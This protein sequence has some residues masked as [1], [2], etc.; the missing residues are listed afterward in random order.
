MT[1]L[2]KDTGW[3]APAVLA[4]ALG[5]A[6]QAL[7]HGGDVARVA[8]VALRWLGI[9]GLA[10]YAVRRRT[11]TPW[12]FVAMVAGAELGFDAPAVC[13]GAAGVLGYLSAA[14]QDHRGS[15]DSGDAGLQGSRGMGT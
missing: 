1:F 5:I 8:G 10:V 9:A 7:G 14:D 4:I 12:I 13:G 3:I 2:R 11:L 15:A 6:V